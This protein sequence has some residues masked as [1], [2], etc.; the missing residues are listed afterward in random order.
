M[1]TNLRNLL[2]RRPRVAGHTLDS[3]NSKR[4]LG[5][6]SS[7]NGLIFYAAAAALISMVV[8]LLPALRTV[9]ASN[10]AAGTLSPGGPSVTWNGMAADYANPVS[11]SEQNCQD[12]VNCDTFKLTIS[13]T[14]ADW[15]GK[16][17]HIQIDWLA[18]A[19]DYALSVHK[20]TNAD[21]SIESSDNPIDSPRNWEAVDINPS[22]F[23]SR[24]TTRSTSSISPPL[25]WTPTKE[26]RVSE[27]QR[28]LPLLRRFL[29][30][31]RRAISTITRHRVWAPVR[32]SLR[33]A[34]IQ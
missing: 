21:P 6:K 18:P 27:R 4:G 29:P 22:V 11:A 17:V 7:T 33:L 10:P 31:R 14:P 2:N 12:G 20:G 24:R 1:P 13:G 25:R 28:Q 5:K 19:F 15:A 26:R 34:S 8:L 32:A 30:H 3:R 16:S 9:S 23:R